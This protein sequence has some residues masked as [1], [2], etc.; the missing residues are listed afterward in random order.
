MLGSFC[1]CLINGSVC[2]GLSIP[3]TALTFPRTVATTT[4]YGCDCAWIRLLFLLKTVF[5]ETGLLSFKYT[6]FFYRFSP[7]TMF[8]FLVEMLYSCCFRGEGSRGKKDVASFKK[9]R[10]GFS[11]KML[12]LFFKTA[13]SFSK[14]CYVFFHPLS[15][16]PKTTCSKAFHPKR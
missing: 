10:N 12:R 6:A 14:S 9:R 7:F 2:V 16:H 1:G 5:T 15:L 3:K 8:T 13:M 4:R 11:E